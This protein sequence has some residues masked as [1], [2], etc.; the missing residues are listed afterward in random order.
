MKK[1]LTT[2]AIILCIPFLC[3]DSVK[4][5]NDMCL[6]IFD[7]TRY[8]DMSSGAITH[9]MS[10][11]QQIVDESRLFPNIFYYIQELEDNHGFVIS[12]VFD[13][14]LINPA[15]GHFFGSKDVIELHLENNSILTLPNMNSEDRGRKFI[16]YSSV[17]FETQY[18]MQSLSN[19][20]IEKV[21]LKRG[22]RIVFTH[23]IN[24]AHAY[25]FGLNINC[26][27]ILTDKK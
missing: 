3:T 26:A 23:W 10:E 5:Q 27:L 2:L 18:A 16:F 8:F 20:K 13:D 24:K 25:I 19:S 14:Q 17:L 7:W 4:A 1:L 22:N 15:L 11:I 6:T 9:S 21:I 12:F